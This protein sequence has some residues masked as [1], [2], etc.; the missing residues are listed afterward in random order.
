MI[1]GKIRKI[2]K[3]QLWQKMFT[4]A[5]IIFFAGC[6][7]RYSGP[8]PVEGGVLFSIKAPGAK[9]VVISGS[10]NRWDTEKDLLKGPDESGIWSVTIPLNERRVEYIYIIDGEK[11]V[12]DPDAPFANDGLGGRNSVFEAEKS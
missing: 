5:F 9:K 12:L 10:F 2:F 11:W 7:A 1:L 8:R 4:L 3:M 6:F